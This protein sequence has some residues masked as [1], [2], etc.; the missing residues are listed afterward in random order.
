MRGMANMF[1]DGEFVKETDD[2]IRFCFGATG[3][4]NYMVYFDN[5][6]L[7]VTDNVFAWQVQDHSEI[8][9]YVIEGDYCA[10]ANVGGLVDDEME[11]IGYNYYVWENGAYH[12]VYSTTSYTHHQLVVV[13][14]LPAEGAVNVLYKVAYYKA[15]TDWTDNADYGG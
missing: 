11:I 6:N 12:K 9:D 4:G 7:E 10:P 3:N 13:S 15:I 1:C 2:V 5:I 8:A 14:E